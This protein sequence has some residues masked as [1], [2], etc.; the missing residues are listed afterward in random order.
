MDWE[1]KARAYGFQVPVF[2]I[3]IQEG[4][5]WSK[6]QPKKKRV[7]PAEA[8]LQNDRYRSCPQMAWGSTRREVWAPTACRPQCVRGFLA[9]GPLSELC[10]ISYLRRGTSPGCSSPPIPSHLIAHVILS[11]I[12]PIPNRPRVGA[13]SLQSTQKTV[14]SKCRFSIQPSCLLWIPC[15]AVTSLSLSPSL[16]RGA[17]ARTRSLSSLQPKHP[18]SEPALA[19]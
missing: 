14:N 17:F 5:R 2:S 9:H 11:I 16:T 18:S 4:N 1:D 19:R 15:R 12:I 13:V 10:R 7:Q 3:G 6:W 8:S